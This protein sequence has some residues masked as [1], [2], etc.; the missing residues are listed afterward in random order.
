MEFFFTTYRVEK[1]E[2]FFFTEWI[3]VISGLTLEE[4]EKYVKKKT[5]GPFGENPRNYRI[6][7]K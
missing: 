6:V 1:K 4:A 2:G 5:A 3:I 7:K